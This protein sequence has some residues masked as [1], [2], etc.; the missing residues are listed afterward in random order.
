MIRFARWPVLIVSPI[1]LLLAMKL[2]PVIWTLDSAN[3][4]VFVA[5]LCAGGIALAAIVLGPRYS[6][7]PSCGWRISR[8]RCPHSSRAFA[9]SGGAGSLHHR[10]DHE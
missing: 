8:W 7:R 9:C 2:R 10:I 5:G 6:R 3:V 4:T 1:V